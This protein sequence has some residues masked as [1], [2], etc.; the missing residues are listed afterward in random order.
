MESY[1]DYCRVKLILHHPF[2]EWKNLLLINDQVYDLYVDA[3]VAYMER[4]L[5]LSDFYTDLKESSNSDSDSD[6]DLDSESDLNN[7]N[8]TTLTVTTPQ[9]PTTRL[10]SPPRDNHIASDT[11]D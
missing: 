11:V 10:G 6:S 9:R 1:S 8:V 4:Y 3:F 5:H 7:I 2:V